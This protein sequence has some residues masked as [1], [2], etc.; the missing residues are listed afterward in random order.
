VP[1]SSLNCFAVSRPHHPQCPTA[2]YGKAAVRRPPSAFR[3]PSLSLCLYLSSSPS[4]R[5]SLCLSMTS[6]RPSPLELPDSL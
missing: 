6:S 4:P 5:P 3:F 1:S 2:T